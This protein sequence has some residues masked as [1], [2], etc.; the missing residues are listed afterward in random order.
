MNFAFE[1]IKVVAT[2]N[3]KKAVI[4]NK[5]EFV[6]E[7]SSTELILKDTILYTENCSKGEEKYIY[8]EL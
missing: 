2:K 7:K 1:Q 5:V 4:Q 8:F 6:I 3:N